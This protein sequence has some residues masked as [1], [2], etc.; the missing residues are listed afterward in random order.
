MEK[1]GL[2]KIVRIRRPGK[3][4]GACFV[5]VASLMALL[6]SGIEGGAK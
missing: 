2:V 5:Q 3:M 1:A 6:R 4:R